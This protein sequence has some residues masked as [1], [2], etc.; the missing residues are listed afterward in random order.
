MQRSLDVY[1]TDIQ[2]F[3]IMKNKILM[4]SPTEV[5]LFLHIDCQ[6]IKQA[7]KSPLYYDYCNLGDIS[8]WH[9][10]LM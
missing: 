3:H 2:D 4:E 6:P 8:T 9:Y 5:V 1:E 7:Q 10:S